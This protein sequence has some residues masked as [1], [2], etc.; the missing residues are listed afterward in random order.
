MDVETRTRVADAEVAVIGCILIEPE[1]I[2]EVA[3]RLTAEEFLSPTYR[4]IFEAALSLWREKK[5]V[6]AVTVLAALSPE[7]GTV[8]RD[9]MDA[10]PTAVRWEHYC[11]LLA[12]GSRM[13]RVQSIAR[14]ITDAND[15][16][17]VSALLAKCNSLMA[18]RQ[19][20]RVT[21]L[22][23]GLR[24]FYQRQDRGQKPEYFEWPIDALNRRIYTERGDFLILGGLP[25]SGKTALAIQI[26]AHA[27][28][29]GMRTGIFSLETSD[30][31]IFDRLVAQETTV[32]L[33]AIKRGTLSPADFAAAAN[34]GSISGD[35]P[36]EVVQ[37]AGMTAV[38]IQ[39]Y[40]LARRYELIVVDYL[41]LV[42]ADGRTR[43]E[44]VTNVSLQM[45][46]MAQ[47]AGILVLG[48]SQ[49]SRQE[50]GTRR[51]LGMGD[52]RESGQ[53][54]QDADLVMILDKDRD[55][56][57]VLGIAKNKEGGLGDVDLVFDRSHLRFSARSN[58][59]TPGA[60]DDRDGPSPWP[61]KQMPGQEVLT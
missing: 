2:G 14:Q 20:A 53:L 50:K 6:D 55:G 33:E 35:V 41:Q 38:D 54:E 22:Q 37:A 12:E 11:S 27:A 36:L 30:R 15:A 46:S 29:N 25:S 49:L 19:G 5:P 60:A 57:P 26:A 40:A 47:Q 59:P 28:R 9:A 51:R 23:E 24:A 32:P 31:K 4:H 10:T 61:K 7:Y 48:L 45:H 52:L 44:V 56:L 18:E 8:L 17:A 58:R 1:I 34:M 43:V 13:Q 3:M 42:R 39:A 21:T 16:A